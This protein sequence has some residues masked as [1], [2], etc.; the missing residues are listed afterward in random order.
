MRCA[1]ARRTGRGWC[2]GWIATPPA[3]CCWPAHPA[4]RRS[5]P[6]AFRAR[7]VEKTYWAVVAGRPVPAQGRIDLPLRRIGGA[8]GERTEIAEPRRQG[9][10]PRHHRLPHA[11]S[12]RAEAGLAGTAAADRAHASAS[13][14]LRRDRRADPGRREI[15]PAR[16]EQCLRRHGRRGCPSELHLHARALRLPH[17]AGGTLLVEADLPPHMTADVS[18]AGFSRARRRVRRSGADGRSRDAMAR[19]QASRAWCASACGRWRVWSALV[20]VGRRRHRRSVSIP[21]A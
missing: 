14:P 1:S 19:R 18:H 5:S 8:R 15:R 16:P 2:T 11:R 7:A 12:C 10:R 4:P 6:R 9:R 21:T 13:R 20:I 3:C 17:P